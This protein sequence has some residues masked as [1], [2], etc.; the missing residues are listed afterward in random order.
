M[1][2]RAFRLAAAAAALPLLLALGGCATM[3]RDECISANW[4]QVGYSDGAKGLSSHHI[5]EHAKACAEHH[6]QVNLDDYL[7]GH[8]QGTVAYCQPDNGFMVGRSGVRT[9]NVV[10][11][12]PLRAAFFEQHRRGLIVYAIEADL[13]SRRSEAADARR[14]IRRIDDRINEVRENLDKKDLPSD[15]RKSLLDEYNRLVE[16]KERH[17]RQAVRYEREATQVEIRLA[18]QLR[19]FGR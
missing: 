12:D 13:N 17:L 9:I 10:C 16:E 6:V 15:R 11:P 4:R 3:N 18:D 7:A 19:E 14:H 5:E 8:R 2:H 1:T